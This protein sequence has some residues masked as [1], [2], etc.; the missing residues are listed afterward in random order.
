[1]QGGDGEQPLLDVR[2]PDLSQ[3]LQGV[4]LRHYQEN[5]MNMKKLVIWQAMPKDAIPKSP[6]KTF[7]MQCKDVSGVGYNQTFLIQ[8]T[9]PGMNT[10]LL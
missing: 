2:F 1:L 4:H 3:H 10:F 8:R 7:Q 6:T 9:Q 5:F